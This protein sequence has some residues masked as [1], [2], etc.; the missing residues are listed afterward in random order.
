[1][2]TRPR[3]ERRS[4]KFVDPDVQG[5]LVRRMMLHGVLVLLVLCVGLLATQGVQDGFSQPWTQLVQAVVD[6]YGVV[7]SLLMC[8]MPVVIAD[9]IRLS[10]R[11][12][13]PVLA[14]RETLHRLSRGEDVAELRFREGDFWAGMA[15]DVNRIARRINDSDVVTH[16]A[17]VIYTDFDERRAT[18]QFDQMEELFQSIRD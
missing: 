12:V 17:P 3:I 1:M 8:L 5:A 10:H 4:L 18:S 9:L 11:M 15:R 14:M 2:N 6:R 16:R 13:G 7:L